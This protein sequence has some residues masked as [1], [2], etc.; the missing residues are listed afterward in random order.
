MIHGESDHLRVLGGRE[1]R[2]RGEGDKSET[3]GSQGKHAPVLHV[4][5]PQANLPEGEST[6]PVTGMA[7]AGLTEEPGVEA[8]HAGIWTGVVRE[9][10][11]LLRWRHQHVWLMS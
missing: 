9:L 4:R 11:V 10:V 5:R 2:A 7:E 3:Q 1:S 6:F 8:P